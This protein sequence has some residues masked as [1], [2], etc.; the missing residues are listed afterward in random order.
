M[1]NFD[2]FSENNLAI[3]NDVYNHGDSI[4]AVHH[5]VSYKHGR[6]PTL[7]AARQLQRASGSSRFEFD[8]VFEAF[9]RA[10][11]SK[12]SFNLEHHTDFETFS[13][14]VGAGGRSNPSA[15]KFIPSS[16]HGA[17]FSTRR[18]PNV[19]G[20]DSVLLP[21]FPLCIN[22]ARSSYIIRQSLIKQ[23]APKASQTLT[24]TDPP[25]HF[26]LNNQS[27]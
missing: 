9:E 26:H 22:F 13:D 27:P 18:G 2:D 16:R 23:T 19:E 24:V 21:G 1:V 14:V 11:F 3:K 4:S 17:S 8:R 20:N 6:L 10:R 7:R 25:Q 15:F 5:R 12:L